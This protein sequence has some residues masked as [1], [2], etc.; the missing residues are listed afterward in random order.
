[1]NRHP[2]QPLVSDSR[3]MLLD[4][5]G[6]VPTV[7]DVRSHFEHHNHVNDLKPLGRPCHDCAVACGMYAPFSAALALLPAAE[8]DVHSL[9]WF[10]HNNPN[11]ACAGNIEF[12]RLAA[13]TQ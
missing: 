9:R 7:D 1:M 2:I 4:C 8:R 11:R 3:K 13:A 5:W 10:C 12:Q 6:S